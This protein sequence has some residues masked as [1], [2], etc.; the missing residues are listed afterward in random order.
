MQRQQTLDCQPSQPAAV[1]EA[2]SSTI[3]LAAIIEA[4][5][6]KFM[7]DIARMFNNTKYSDTTVVIYSKELPVHK[8]V[9]CT[10]SECFEKA[11]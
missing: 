4:R 11:F 7:R 1:L 8:S 9:I 6:A 10:Q 2:Q 3:S 5:S